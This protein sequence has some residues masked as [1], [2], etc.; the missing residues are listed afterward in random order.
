MSARPGDPPTEDTIPVPRQRWSTLALVS[1]VLSVLPVGSVVA[2]VAGLVA[3]LQLRRRPDLRGAGIA[4][5]G[6]AV[7]IVASSLMVGGAWSL[8]REFMLLSER[9][10]VALR[11][12]WSGDATLFR[13]QMAGPGREAST[14]TLRAW[15]A[16]VRARLGELRGLEISK[17]PPPAPEKPLPDTEVRAAYLGSFTGIEGA[18]PVTVTFERP[19]AASGA[20]QIRVRRFEFLLPDGTRIVFPPDDQQPAA[21]AATD[22]PAGR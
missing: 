7:G 21:S 13:Q 4:W 8:W 10:S 16:P 5:A 18:V 3:L 1:L 22:R 9:P 11:A 17:T 20:A 12:A 15:A 6:I 2:P 19:A 14:E